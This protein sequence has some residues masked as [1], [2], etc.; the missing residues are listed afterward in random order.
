MDITVDKKNGAQTSLKVEVPWE[1]VAGKLEQ[2]FRRLAKNTRIP[3][4]RKGRAPRKLFEL[5]FG[6]KDIEQEALKSLFP[7]VFREAI[8]K[9]K[10]P[11]ELNKLHLQKGLILLEE[12]TN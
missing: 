2:A 4:F 1:R 9:E 3:G 5:R 8:K 12:L 6:T 7:E 11:V 10:D